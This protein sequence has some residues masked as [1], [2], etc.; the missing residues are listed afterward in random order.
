VSAARCFSRVCLPFCSLRMAY[1]GGWVRF[2]WCVVDVGRGEL[3]K[4]VH[5]RACPTFGLYGLFDGDGLE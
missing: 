2:I 3:W 5:I 1:M 4:V